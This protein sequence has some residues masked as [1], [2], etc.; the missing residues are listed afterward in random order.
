MEKIMKKYVF[1][2]LAL[3]ILSA[4]SGGN[5]ASVAGTWK[6]VSYGSASN[7]TPAVSDVDTSIEFKD[8]QVNGNVGC[9]GF[10]GTY[11]IDGD[12]IKFSDVVSTLMFCEG[13]VGDQ[14]L[15]T[16]AVLRESATYVLDGD[17]LTLT[18]AD[19]NAMVI[20]ARK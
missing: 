20:L 18:S 10:G 5:S 3:L 7:Q 4:C 11:E 14:E 13:P 8:G 16:L 12:K 15:G 1:A 17:T 19:G 6:L 9:N 2:L